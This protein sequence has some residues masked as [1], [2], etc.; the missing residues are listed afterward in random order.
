MHNRQMIFTLALLEMTLDDHSG[1][2]AP[3]RVMDRPVTAKRLAREREA[4]GPDDG[5]PRP[6][7]YLEGVNSGTMMMFPFGVYERRY[8]WSGDAGESFL[9]CQQKRGGKVVGIW[10]IRLKEVRRPATGWHFGNQSLQG[11]LVR[12]MASQGIEPAEPIPSIAVKALQA[13]KCFAAYR[14][15]FMTDGFSWWALTPDGRTVERGMRPRIADSTKFSAPYL[16]APYNITKMESKW[17][18]RKRAGT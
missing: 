4:F 6:Y 16:G 18:D 3:S 5:L 9:N 14:L 15:N 10:S 2:I 13:D 17:L 11:T 1:L 8:Q 12:Y 7:A